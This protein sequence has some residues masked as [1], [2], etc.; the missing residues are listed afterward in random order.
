MAIH[1]HIVMLMGI[2]GKR[3]YK[4]KKLYSSAITNGL[5]KLSYFKQL[6]RATKRK[7]LELFEHKI[8]RDVDFFYCAEFDEVGEKGNCGKQCDKYAPRNGTSGICRH[9]K[10][11]YDSTGITLIIKGSIL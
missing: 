1:R 11:C 9:N 8:D 4:V 3:G 7:E 6:L 5:Y 10:P 2:L